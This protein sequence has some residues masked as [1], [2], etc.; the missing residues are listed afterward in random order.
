MKQIDELINF[1]S[2]NLKEKLISSHQL[3]SELIL[4]NVL[5]KSREKILTSLDQRV[6]KETILAFNQ[7]INRRAKKNQ[8]HIYLK[9]KNFGAKISWLIAL[10]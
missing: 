3:D 6:S 8:W 9:K 1:G 5:N 7:L 2:K 4:S 10:L